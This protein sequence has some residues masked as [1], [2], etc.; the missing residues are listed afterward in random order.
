MLAN[1]FLKTIRERWL[2]W[3]VAYVSLVALLLMAMAVY[4]EVDPTFID[5]MPEVYRSMIGVP[6]GADVASLSIN[7]LVGTYGALTV[8]A[9]ALAMGAALIAGEERKGTF[10]LLLGNPRSRTHVLV[11]KTAAL[12]LLTSLCVLA[13]F[14]AVVASAAMLDVSI[15]GMDV[16]AFSLHLLLNCLFYGFLALAIGAAT[17]NRGAALGAALGVMVLSFV[18]VGIL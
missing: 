11:S 16:G 4:A 13:L 6:E 18:A 5:S 12:V 8:C 1:V 9:M 3:L 14:G 15:E 10:G 7:A 2:G 17:G